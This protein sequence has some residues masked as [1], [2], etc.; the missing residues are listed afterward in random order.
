MPFI[1]AVSGMSFDFRNA[2]IREAAAGYAEIC[3]MRHIPLLDLY[4]DLAG[5]ADHLGG[6]E[7]SDGLHTH[8]GGYH[9]VAGRVRSWRQWQ[10]STWPRP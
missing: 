2:D 6:L 4:G 10:E 7:A 8:A 5:D 3:A 1:P 9:A